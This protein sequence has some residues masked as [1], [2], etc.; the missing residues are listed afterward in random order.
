MTEEIK[1]LITSLC[2][3]ALK[4]GGVQNIEEVHKV[5]NYLKELETPAPV[6]TEAIVETPQPIDSI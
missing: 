5:V 3:M 1:K 6:E 2:D 4:V